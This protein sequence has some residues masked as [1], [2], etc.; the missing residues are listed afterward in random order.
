MQE[1]YVSGKHLKHPTHLRLIV[2]YESVA[3]Y[4][5]AGSTSG[6]SAKTLQVAQ[7]PSTAS[8][9]NTEDVPSV[10]FNV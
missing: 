4:G 6:F 5:Y 8:H 9:L 3:T 10:P 7:Q 1:M 2:K